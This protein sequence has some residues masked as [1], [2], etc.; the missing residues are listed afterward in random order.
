MAYR[1]SRKFP[2]AGR[3]EWVDLAKGISIL[4]VV[5]MH[6]TLGVEAA[7]GAVGWLHPLVEFAKPFRMP[8][9]FLISGLFL[10]RTIEA[11][12]RRYL[13]R[14]IIH[15][16]YFYF[17]WLSIQFA[18]KGPEI[19]MQEGASTAFDAFAQAFYQPFGTLWFIYMLPVFFVFTRLVRGLPVW[20]VLAWAGV[21]E[22]LP[23]ATGSVIYDEFAARYVYFFIGY[24]F[25]ARV[26]AFQAWTAVHA[27][28]AAAGL[29]LWALVHGALSLT[30]ISATFAGYAE[31]FISNAAALKW[32]DLPGLSLVA[33]LAGTAALVT[34]SGFLTRVR[35]SDGLRWLGSH[36]IVIYLAFF[37][38]MAATRIA[39]V[40]SG[41]V[42]DVGTMSFIT[43]TA[44]VAGPII[45]YGLIQ[46]SGWGRFLFERPAWARIEGRSAQKESLV[47]GE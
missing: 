16:F 18:L 34:F 4:L 5:M 46:W 37:L 15:F 42:A 14:K 43:W 20:L 25:A 19:A 3:V 31:A 39:L 17:L 22:I 11:P 45:L 29:C 27:T 33:A 47:P 23:I 21:L 2:H 9:F 30:P 10:A 12:W 35:W 7:A 32:T 26:F 36:S 13:D 40:K 41:V 1:T 44:A 28:S 6:S 24:A 38:P 8:A